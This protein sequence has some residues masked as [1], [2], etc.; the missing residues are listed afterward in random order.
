MNLLDLLRMAIN[1][2]LQVA[3]GVAL[4]M[5]APFLY[6][7]VSAMTWEEPWLGLASIYIAAWLVKV[8]V[9]PHFSRSESH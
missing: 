8:T 9:M 3:A 4:V 6:I 2:S 5:A 1:L 7:F